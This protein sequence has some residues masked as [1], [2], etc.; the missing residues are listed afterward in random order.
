MPTRYSRTLAALHWLLAL[1]IIAELFAG[2]VLL[3]NTPNSDPDK[4]FGLSMHMPIGLVILAL[5][6]LRV[7]VRIRSA[8]PPHAD[9][10]NDILNRAGIWAHWLLYAL[11]FIMALSGIVMARGA[12][13]PDIVFGGS[14]APLPAEFTGPARIVH[15]FA[16]TALIVLIIGHIGAAIYHQHV[17]KD[18]LLARMS[19]RR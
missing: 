1:M 7:I 15:G 8:K 10:G 13:L 9:I 16:A 18:G 14:G 11:V 12:G 4:L 6:I 3:G 2:K 5:M 19:L 17:R